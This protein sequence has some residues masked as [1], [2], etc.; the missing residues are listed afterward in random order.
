MAFTLNG[1]G[2]TFHGSAD[3]HPDGSYIV[4]TWV[5]LAFIS[6]ISLGSMRV[7]PVSQ[8]H[9]PW[10]RRSGQQYRSL[11]V[12]LHVPH[13]CEGWGVTLGLFLFLSIASRH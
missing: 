11:K 2:T 3:P 4:T 8:D 12:P 7:L 1:C 9:L 6:L 5:V 10:Y 13:L